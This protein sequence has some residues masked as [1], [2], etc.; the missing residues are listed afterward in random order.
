MCGLICP[1]VDKLEFNVPEP[2]HPLAPPLGEL[3]AP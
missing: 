2:L 1:E 3:A